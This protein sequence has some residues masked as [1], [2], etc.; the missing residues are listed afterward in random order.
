[1]VV[2]LVGFLLVVGFLVVVGLVVCSAVTFVAFA[3]VLTGRLLVGVAAVVAFLGGNLVA[4]TVFWVVCS[5]VA[6]VTAAL[7]GSVVTGLL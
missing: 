7:G 4:G 3:A 5:V 1:M 6:V 2:T